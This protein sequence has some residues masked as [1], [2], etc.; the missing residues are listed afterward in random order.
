MSVFKGVDILRR[1][2]APDGGGGVAVHRRI[3]QG[4][5]GG[6]CIEQSPEELRTAVHIKEAVWI[7]VQPNHSCVAEESA[8]WLS[9]DEVEA[10]VHEAE[11]VADDVRHGRVFGGETVDGDH[12]ASSATE[13]VGDNTGGVTHRQDTRGAVA[14][15]V[16]GGVH[17]FEEVGKFLGMLGLGVDE[18]LGGYQRRSWWGEQLRCVADVQG[19]DL[20]G[21]SRAPAASSLPQDV[22]D[23]RGR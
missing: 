2:Q 8:G 10:C 15:R 17:G 3:L 13:G 16:D 4:D 5:K 19:S 1:S 12:V 9:N 20:R 14:R 21:A 23:G 22:H 18:W 11:G 6:V 7:S